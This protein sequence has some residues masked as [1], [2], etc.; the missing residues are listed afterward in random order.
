MLLALL[1]LGACRC[2][3]PAP[4][5]AWEVGAPLDEL[6]RAAPGSLADFV[7]GGPPL[8]VLVERPDEVL[9]L[10]HGEAWLL[11]GPRQVD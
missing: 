6:P 3:E 9:R 1:A 5:R 8:F 10:A 2:G 11:C 7:P 4:E